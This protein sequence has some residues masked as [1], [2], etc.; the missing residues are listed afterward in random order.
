MCQPTHVVLVA[1]TGNHSALVLLIWSTNTEGTAAAII[2]LVGD[3]I[4]TIVTTDILMITTRWGRRDELE[5]YTLV[6]DEVQLTPAPWV[7]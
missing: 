7:N 1:T 2:T 5:C 6:S 3:E 4:G